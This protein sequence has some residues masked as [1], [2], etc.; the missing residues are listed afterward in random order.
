M[1]L[2]W[3]QAELLRITSNYGVH[4]S[5]YLYKSCSLYVHV[6]DLSVATVSFLR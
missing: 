1:V 2:L 6:G 5:M 3:K 4:Y